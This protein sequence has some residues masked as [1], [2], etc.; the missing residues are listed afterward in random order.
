VLAVSWGRDVATGPLLVVAAVGLTA[1]VIAGVH[2]AEV[3]PTG[4]VNRS[5]P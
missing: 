1:A 4:S 2:H 5:A 3:A